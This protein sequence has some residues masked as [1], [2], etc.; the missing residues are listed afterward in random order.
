MKY[1]LAGVLA[2]V[3]TAWPATVA[4]A[5]GWQQWQ[6]VPGVFDVGGPRA[7]GSLVVAGSGRLYTLTSGGALTPFA[8]G[9]DPGAEAYLADSPGVGCFPKDQI[10]VLRLHAPI[11]VTR[12]S[13]DGSSSAPFANVDLP[14]LNGIAFDTA[15][16]FDHRLLVTGPVNGKTEVAA[17]DCNGSVQVI[18]A[19]APVAEGG[20]AVAP[21]GFGGFDG[22][23]I[24]PDELSGIIWA[25]APDGS[26]SQVVNSGLPKGQDTGVE[27]VAFA[28]PGLIAGGGYVYYSDRLT[29]GNPHPGT[30]HVLRLSSADLASSGVHDGDLLAATEG[31]ASMIDVRCEAACHVFSVVPL[32]TSAHGEG[33]LVFALTP[34]PPSPVATAVQVAYA[35]PGRGIPVAAVVALLA[36]VLGGAAAALVLA[37]RRR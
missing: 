30:D 1:L 8:R 5:E 28:P 37:R 24:M 13:A 3:L 22:D 10:F 12:I 29:A 6:T 25:I 31:G 21:I 27:S 36:A 17:I 14:S 18:T 34:Q 20:L 9:E 15:G 32:P 11:G 23:L 19:S 26:S 7:D 2:G 33:H 4:A 35:P 16:F